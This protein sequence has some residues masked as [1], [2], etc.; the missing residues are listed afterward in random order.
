MGGKQEKGKDQW[1]KIDVLIRKGR[2]SEVGG[3]VGKK[4]EISGAKR[5]GPHKIQ[6]RRRFLRHRRLMKEKGK[7]SPLNA[8]QGKK[9]SGHLRRGGEAQGE[10]E[11]DHISA[12][13]RKL[14]GERHRAKI[15]EGK[16]P[17][18]GNEGGGAL[19]LCGVGRFSL[20]HF[21]GREKKPYNEVRRSF[22]WHE[23][24]K[25]KAAIIELML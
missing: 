12:H 15:R 8:S 7:R 22:N 9:G 18:F 3:G 16:Y 14:W 4:K 13:K 24:G 21:G 19:Y 10:I 6:I 17:A 25:K 11:S 2:K 20:G 1:K 5:E 23:E